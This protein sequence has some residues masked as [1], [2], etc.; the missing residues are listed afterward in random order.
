MWRLGPRLVCMRS[1][2]RMY[3]CIKD[4]VHVGVVNCDHGHKLIS[5]EAYTSSCAIC[6][7]ACVYHI[8]ILYAYACLYAHIHVYICMS[9]V[10]HDDALLHK[11]IQSTLITHTNTHA[12][13]L[14]CVNPQA[15]TL[16]NARTHTQIHRIC[17]HVRNILR[18]C[19]QTL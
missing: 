8:D 10:C 17:V 13:S 4:F 16:T 14:S 7:Q 18:K 12:L 5:K 15:G 3:A 11:Q 6:M 9:N 1:H 19:F 2:T